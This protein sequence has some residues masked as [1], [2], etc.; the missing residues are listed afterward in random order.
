M[1]ENRNE[2]LLKDIFSA[3]SRGN[4]E[5]LIGAM[6]DDMQW[7]W[8]GTMTWTRTFKGKQSVL[9]ELVAA[10]K[11]TMKQP[12]KFDA[13]RFI[14]E[15]DFVVVEA[16]GQNTTTDGKVYNNNYCWVCRVAEGELHEVREYMDTELVSAVF[17]TVEKPGVK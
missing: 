1:T 12:L 7:T 5:P 15:G 14:A 4:L 9:N 13:Y 16:R 6:A 8:M 10:M 17:G 3:L 11:T 2:R